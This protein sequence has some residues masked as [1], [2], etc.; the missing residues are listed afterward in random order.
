MWSPYMLAYNYTTYLEHVGPILK[1]DLE[2]QLPLF[3]IETEMNR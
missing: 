3:R 1:I 2:P